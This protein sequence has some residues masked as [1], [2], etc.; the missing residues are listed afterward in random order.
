MPSQPSYQ[1]TNISLK[2]GLKNIRRSTPFGDQN[3]PSETREE[4][5]NQTI[6]FEMDFTILAT[7]LKEIKLTNMSSATKEYIWQTAASLENKRN[8]ILQQQ[9]ILNDWA[10]QCR[11][12]DVDVSERI[13][14]QKKSVELHHQ[15]R[16]SQ[17]KT[18]LDYA[19]EVKEFLLEIQR[20]DHSFPAEPNISC[21]LDSQSKQKKLHNAYPLP[22]GDSAAPV[23]PVANTPDCILDTPRKHDGPSPQNTRIPQNPRKIRKKKKKTDFPDEPAANTRARKDGPDSTSPHQL[24]SRSNN[25]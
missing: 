7:Q 9:Q 23:T 1:D 8:D 10:E 3:H 12:I 5:S 21:K 2:T 16:E 19:V 13:E 17:L 20:Q 6:N 11:T 14:N 4:V 25:A 24:Q 15:V 22:E 18:I